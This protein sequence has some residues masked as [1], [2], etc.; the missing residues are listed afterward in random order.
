MDLAAIVDRGNVRITYFV[1]R[2]A[3]QIGGGTGRRDECHQQLL[4]C[5][6]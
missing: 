2:L 3:C 6:G 1:V 5:L 4:G